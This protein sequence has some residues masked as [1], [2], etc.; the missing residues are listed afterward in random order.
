MVSCYNIIKISDKALK[1]LDAQYLFQTKHVKKKKMWRK[2]MKR[3][4]IIS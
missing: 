4:V 1:S 3:K 2:R